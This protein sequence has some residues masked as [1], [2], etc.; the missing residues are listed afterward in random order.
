MSLLRDTTVVPPRP[1][2]VLLGG[3]YL[4]SLIPFSDKSNTWT[5][6]PAKFTGSNGGVVT[7]PKAYG[8][9]SPEPRSQPAASQGHTAH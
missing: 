2:L 5:F 3:F 8:T 9:A 1:K 6:D 4:N 7:D